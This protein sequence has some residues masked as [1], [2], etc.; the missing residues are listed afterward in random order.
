M[1]ICPPFFPHS[2]TNRLIIKPR[3]PLPAVFLRAQLSL[4]TPG[5]TPLSVRITSTSISHYFSFCPP[6]QCPFCVYAFETIKFILPCKIRRSLRIY[7]VP[8]ER[9]EKRGAEKNLRPL[10]MKMYLYAERKK[11]S[12]IKMVGEGVKWG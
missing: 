1:H 3:H 10:D 4:L 9:E 6:S 7:V 2:R 8:R 11:K 12:E 5:P